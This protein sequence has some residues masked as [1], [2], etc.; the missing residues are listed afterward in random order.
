M[1]SA[2]LFILSTLFFMACENDKSAIQEIYTK[3]SGVEIADSVNINYTTGGKVKAVLTSPLMHRIQ[4][5]SLVVFP[6]TLLVTFYNEEGIP[7]SKL[8]AKFGK[9]LEFQNEVFL[10]DSVRVINF[11][12]GDTL[13]TDELMWDRKRTGNEF[14]TNKPVK[15]RTKTQ[16]LNGIGMEANQN[17][18]S[19]HIIESTGII[20]VPNNVLPQ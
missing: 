14:Y 7:E 20:D 8:T 4:D 6:N 3:S 2:K 12:K 15:I 16:I 9:Y 1:R 5:S 19:Y 18:K 13:I 11:L 10:R 17:F